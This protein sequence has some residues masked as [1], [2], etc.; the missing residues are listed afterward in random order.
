L[1]WSASVRRGLPRYCSNKL[2][3]CFLSFIAFASPSRG[4]AP[5]LSITHRQAI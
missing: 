4:S 2:A 5:E 1:L 3:S